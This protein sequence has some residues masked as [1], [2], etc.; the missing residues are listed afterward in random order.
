[1]GDREEGRD[2]EGDVGEEVGGEEAEVARGGSKCKYVGHSMSFQHN[3]NLTPSD[4][5]ESW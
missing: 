3:K 2:E 4:F 1:M 5:Y